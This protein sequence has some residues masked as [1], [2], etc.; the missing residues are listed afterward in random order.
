LRRLRP[1]PIAALAA[2]GAFALIAAAPAPPHLERALAAQR[3]LAAERPDDAGVANDL[4]NL[5]ALA[6]ETKSAEAA[7]LRAIEL[8][9][10]DPSPRFNYGLLLRESGREMAAMR[11]F[12]A[13]VEA[14]PRH[15]WAHY[16]VGEIYQSWGLDRLAR[17]AYVRA[18]RLDP[19]LAD[20]R[21]NPAVLD[22]RA[23]TAA[24]LM[25][26]KEGGGAPVAVPRGYSEPARIAGLLIETPEEKAA[27]AHVGDEPVADEEAEGEGGGGFARLAGGDSASDGGRGELAPGELEPEAGEEEGDESFDDPTA[28]APRVLTGADLRPSGTV[29]QVSPPDGRAAN[30]RSTGGGAPGRTRIA[31]NRPRY[32]PGPGSTGRLDL[33]LAPPAA[34]PAPLAG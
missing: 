5:L 10:S 3:E 11:Q 30:G 6:G 2:L 15:A 19:R 24:M 1:L 14:E 9:P 28:R 26:W 20:A 8:A 29:N 31:P 12:R 27:P 18:F 7:Y 22:N 21:S 16:Q 33:R 23:A 32:V 34:E 13:T 17:K 4:A 25:A